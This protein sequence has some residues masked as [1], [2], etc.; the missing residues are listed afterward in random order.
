MELSE[1]LQE[2]RR[3]KGVT[4]EEVAAAIFVSRTAVSKWESGRGYPNIDSLKNLAN[5]YGVTIDELLSTQELIAAME[6]ENKQTKKH[7]R[8]LVFG[9]I[10][11]SVILL[12]ILPLF[13]LRS[14]NAVL[15]VPLLHLS[16]VKLYV[17]IIYY[18]MVCLVVLFGVLTLS[19]QNFNAVYWQKSKVFV[20]LILSALLVIVFIITLQP[21]AAIFSLVLLIIKGL[22]LIK[23]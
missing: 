14:G 9:L 18:F 5:Y 6:E 11:I 19:L 16:S 21:Y 22:I 2:L 15:S 1:K 3:K 4:Q 23:R 13:A 17:K 7:F 8:D 12:F 10:D 20:S